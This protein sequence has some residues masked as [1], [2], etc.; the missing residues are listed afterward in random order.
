MME[1]LFGFLGVIVGS[2]IP[3]IKDSLQQRRS[4]T[5]QGTYLAVRVI[6]ILDEYVDKCVEV[7]QDDGT[8]M[9]QAAERDCDGYDLYTP[10]VRLPP[11]PIF[12]DDVN[13]KSL[14]SDL[15]YR[16]LA[17]PNTARSTDKSICFVSDTDF[18]PDNEELFE[19]RMYSYANLGLEAIEIV[20]ALRKRYSVTEK[21]ADKWDADWNPK[22]YL[23]QKKQGVEDMWA[24]RS[25]FFSSLDSQTTDSKRE[26]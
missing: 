23:Q 19:T 10:Q 6:C 11:A 2:F 15:M 7:V 16:I 4:R 3:W 5:E 18:T 1:A 25:N 8:V 24:K 13:W 22:Q 14:D 20:E 17:F 9:G 12:P 26:E 21:S